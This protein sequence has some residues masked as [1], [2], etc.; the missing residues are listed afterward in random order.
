MHPHPA[1]FA[2][3]MATGIVSIAS[4]LM[5]L[6]SVALCLQLMN[7]AFYVAL[8]AFMIRRALRFPRAFA[9]DVGDHSRG[10]GFFTW[11]AA[12]CVLSTQCVLVYRV[13]WLAV[14][15]WAL[16][17]F[18]FVLVTY[19]VFAALTVNRSKPD[20]ER[21]L[22]GGWLVAVVA[23]QAVSV[24]SCQLVAVAPSYQAALLFLAVSAW[25]C[26][27]LLYVWIGG[28]VFYRYTFFA[29]D[30]ADLQPPYWINMGA[31]AI[32]TLAG[33]CLSL[34]APQSELLTSLLPSLRGG[35]V[36]AWAIATWWIP[37]LVVLGWW[38][39]VLRRVPV[40]YDPL[41]WSAVF[42]LGM[43]T[44]CSVKLIEAL[45]LGFLRPLPQVFLYIALS[46]WGLT[47]AGLCHSLFAR[48]AVER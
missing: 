45:D 40:R 34:A 32:T 5:G 15:L 19:A 37:L 31:A 9:A 6:R 43:Y 38:R 29:M 3:V 13:A 2:L 16:G 22:N 20:L 33:A 39:H 21:G 28:L 14:G 30:P 8:W 44:A 42:P 41:Y 1:Y 12:S 46:A 24:S 18:L 47:F 36:A 35:S 17:V 4:N 23:A 27:G 48:A 25:S 7:G 11:A 26:G 10:V